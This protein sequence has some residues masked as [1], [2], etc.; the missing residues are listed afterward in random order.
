MV[1]NWPESLKPIFASVEGKYKEEGG[2]KDFLSYK[3][4]NFKSSSILVFSASL[5]FGNL[6]IFLPLIW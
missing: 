3:E 1:L 2:E 4:F 5:F 6:S